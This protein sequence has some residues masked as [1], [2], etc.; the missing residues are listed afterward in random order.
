MF[1]IKYLLFQ[2]IRWAILLYSIACMLYGTFGILSIAFHL[3][4]SSNTGT[5]IWWTVG[6]YNV[7]MPVKA[8]LFGSIL[9]STVTYKSDGGSEV[10]NY[11]HGS[12]FNQ[13]VNEQQ[14]LNKNVTRVTY[15]PQYAFPAKQPVNIA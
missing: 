7:G 13:V 8:N 2:F 15:N 10:Y 4:A 5:H 14:S 6:E 3:P 9:D 1:Y 11:Y 12:P